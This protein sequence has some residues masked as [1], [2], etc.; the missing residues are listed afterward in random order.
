MRRYGDRR[1]P[2]WVTEISWPAAKGRAR[3]HRHRDRRSRPGAAAARGLTALRGGAAA[4]ARCERVYWYTWLSAESSASVFAWSGL[5][6]LHD[7][8]VI[9]TPALAAFRATA[10][11]L[12]R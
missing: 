6:R 7:G 5:R 3:T 4:A 9:S 12:R 8:A 2:V 11:R 1:K 10:R